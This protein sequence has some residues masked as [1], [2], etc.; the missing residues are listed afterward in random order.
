MKLLDKLKNNAVS[1]TEIYQLTLFAYYH[2]DK[3][4]ANAAWHTWTRL[5]RQLVFARLLLFV[6]GNK[7]VLKRVTDS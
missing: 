4:E 3:M 2:V 5:R 1:L 6:G 7:I